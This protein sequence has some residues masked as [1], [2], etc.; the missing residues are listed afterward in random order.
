MDFSLHFLCQD[1]N[2]SISSAIQ[3]ISKFFNSIDCN[4]NFPSSHQFIP[5]CGRRNSKL[6]PNIGRQSGPSNLPKYLLILPSLLVA[7][8]RS[9]T[10]PRITA[11]RIWYELP[12]QQDE[13]RNSIIYWNFKYDVLIDL[14]RCCLLQFSSPVFD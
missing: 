9:K 5:C 12:V 1:F 11:Y 3:K 7:N 10:K 13:T 4:L 2:K 14:K 8:S 6:D